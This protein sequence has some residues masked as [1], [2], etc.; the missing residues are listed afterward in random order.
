MILIYNY[1]INSYLCNI[2]LI[3]YININR[4]WLPPE[5]KESNT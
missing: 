1:L 4:K 3:Y 2:K 5:Y